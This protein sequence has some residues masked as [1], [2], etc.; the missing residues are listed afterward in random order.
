MI[1]HTLFSW[2][3]L[4]AVVLL[5]ALWLVQYWLCLRPIDRLQLRLLG[6]AN[7]ASLLA[8]I[9]VLATGVPLLVLFEPGLELRLLD[10][11]FLAKLGLT[12]ALALLAL[13][14]A[15]R[16]LAWSREARRLP[17]FAPRES[18]WGQLRA[19]LALQLGVLVVLGFL[20]VLAAG[21]AALAPGPPN[22]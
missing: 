4:L 22:F 3:H 17:V 14:S 15:W 1:W 11:L 13:P 2:L 6:A 9:G 19:L 5:A 20:A 16:I 10:P 12:A 18:E 21:Q 8:A 7:L